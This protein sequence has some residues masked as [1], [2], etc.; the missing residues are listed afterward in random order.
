M[1]RGGPASLGGMG[2]G[3]LVPARFAT[4]RRRRLDGLDEPERRGRLGPPAAGPPGRRFRYRCRSSRTSSGRETWPGYS[5][6]PSSPASSSSLLSDCLQNIRESVGVRIPGTAVSLL[7]TAGNFGAFPAP[8]VTRGLI[9]V[10]GGYV[11]AFARDSILTGLGLGLPCSVPSAENDG[12]SERQQ[13]RHGG[14]REYQTKPPDSVP[15]GHSGE[16]GLRERM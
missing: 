2:R 15:P 3:L 6:R 5:A 4:G 10:C 8:L 12:I 11:A 7:T 13:D 1:A 14:R 9:D 16:A